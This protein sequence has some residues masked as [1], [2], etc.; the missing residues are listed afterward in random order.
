[1]NFFVQHSYSYDMYHLYVGLGL[2]SHPLRVVGPTYDTFYLMVPL[3]LMT[4]ES[5]LQAN[6]N[7]PRSLIHHPHILSSENSGTFHLSLAACFPQVS[8]ITFLLNLLFMDK[9]EIIFD[10]ATNLV[11]K[12]ED[13]SAKYTGL[14]Q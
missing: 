4:G 12:Q 7:A 5:V 6:R 14:F 2:I 1:M 10:S 8:A 11:K 3:L 13:L 9:A